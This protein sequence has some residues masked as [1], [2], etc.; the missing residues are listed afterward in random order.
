MKV[1]LIPGNFYMIGNELLEY[2][3]VFNNAKEVPHMNCV[4]VIGNALMRKKIIRHEEHL[5]NTRAMNSRSGRFIDTRI[6]DEDNDLMHIIKNALADYTHNDFKRLFDNTSEMNNMRR[7]IEKGEQGSLSWNRFRVML[8]KLGL[9][10]VLYVKN[11]GDK[12]TQEP[13]IDASGKLIQ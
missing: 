9:E 1:N 12:S 10:Y 4:Y 8:D 6:K 7:A 5:E 13:K 3:G 11:K 2:L